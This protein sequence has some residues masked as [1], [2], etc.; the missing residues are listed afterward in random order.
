MARIMIKW[1]FTVPGASSQIEFGSWLMMSFTIGGERA[2][3]TSNLPAMN[4]SMAVAGSRII[5]K[6]MASR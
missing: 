5:L 2:T 6:S 4:A 3:A 1:R